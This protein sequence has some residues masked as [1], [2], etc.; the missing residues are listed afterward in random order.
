MRCPRYPAPNEQ[1]LWRDTRNRGHHGNATTAPDRRNANRSAAGRTGTVS[2]CPACRLHRPCGIDPR[3][4]LVRVL[5]GLRRRNARRAVVVRIRR[6]PRETPS[7]PHNHSAGQIPW[8][9][10]I[11]PDFTSISSRSSRSRLGMSRSAFSLVNK[12]R[13]SLICV[14]W[15]KR[16]KICHRPEPWRPPTPSRLRLH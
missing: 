9:F 1:G 7:S 8:C 14:S 12:Q 4:D 6:P 15:L 13:I 3:N 2:A 16:R 11:K 5:P 10:A